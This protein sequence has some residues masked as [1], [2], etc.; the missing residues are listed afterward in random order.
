[1]CKCNTRAVGRIQNFSVNKISVAAMSTHF[2][3]VFL[4]VDS[5]SVT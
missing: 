5:T 4:N 3:I 1:M 2:T